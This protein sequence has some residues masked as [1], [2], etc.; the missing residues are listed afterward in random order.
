MHAWPELHPELLA[1]VPEREELRH[2]VR[3][4]LAKHADHEQVRASADSA[5][6]YSE[7]LWR[8]LNA[9]LEVGRLAVPEAL[10]GNG[11]GLQELFVVVEE[12]GAA[13]A[14]EPVL[15]SAVLGCQAL[16]AADDPDS[17]E[18]LLE[19][20]LRGELVVTVATGPAPLAAVQ[21]TDGG[22]RV[23]GTRTR[24]LHGAAAGLVVVNATTPQ[25]TVLLAVA[26]TDL[27]VEP[28]VAVDLTRRQADLVLDAAPARPLVGVARATTV[29]DR[30]ALIGRAALAAEHTGI[31]GELLDRTREYVVQRDQFGR[32][33]GSFQAIKH[34]L[35]DV[36]VDRERARSAS[37]YAAA[38]LDGE[39]ETAALPV[40]VAAAVCADAA[41]R[42]AHEA[43]QLHGGI[44]FTW[45]HRAHYYVRRVLGDEGLFGATREQRA[46]IAELVG[47]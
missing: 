17:I 14:P 10:G 43:V 12:C 16:S 20:A 37:R 32:P 42:T 39:P 34:R 7:D 46:R 1:P 18:D 6:G 44:G 2:I 5:T 47:V 19:P 11:F 24:V 28:C 41:M 33:I 13:L 31:V 29:R 21:D 27:T 25:G 9:E 3:E 36:L 40:A 8:L 30:L 15:S 4:V 38:V 45:E 35:A 26:A 23:S 22:W